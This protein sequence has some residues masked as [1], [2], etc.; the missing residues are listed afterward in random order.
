LFEGH[1][2]HGKSTLSRWVADRMG[3]LLK[4]INAAT[5]RRSSDIVDSLMQLERNTYLFID[6]IHRL[7]TKTQEILYTA[8]EDFYVNDDL[9]EK[10]ELEPFTLIGATT[11]IGLLSAPMKSR[12]K[13][14]FQLEGYSPEEIREIIQEYAG[15]LSMNVDA[16]SLLPYCRKNPRLAKDH[17]EWIQ[18]YCEAKQRQADSDLIQDAMRQ[19]GVYD[20]GLTVRD[21]EYLTFLYKQSTWVGLETLANCLGLDKL[22]IRD[23]IEPFLVTEGYLLRGKRGRYPTQKAKEFLKKIKQEKEKEKGSQ[24]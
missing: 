21:I 12:F 22:T 23:F 17:V 10:V 2:G 8:C 3:G 14:V 20:N 6:E 5:V 13:H 4:E 18:D 19:K 15:K 1:A 7:P 9:L 24:P 11:S 16:E